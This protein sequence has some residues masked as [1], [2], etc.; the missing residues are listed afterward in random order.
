MEEHKTWFWSRRRKRRTRRLPRECTTPD[1]CPALAQGEEV[2]GVGLSEL[3][4]EAF[5]LAVASGELVITPDT[6]VASGLEEAFWRWCLSAGVE[7]RVRTVTWEEVERTLP[8]VTKRA[9][10]RRSA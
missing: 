9:R 3:E 10:P 7:Y 8:R 6:P 2:E 1:I 5:D 4:I